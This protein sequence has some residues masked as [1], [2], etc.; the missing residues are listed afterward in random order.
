MNMVKTT[1]A[2]IAIVFGLSAAFA[3]EIRPGAA[4]RCD[5]TLKG[6]V[7]EG[8]SKA[9]AEQ[10]APMAV[11]RQ[12]TLCLD[13]GGGDYLEALEIIRII[14]ASDAAIAT[15]LERSARCLSA[16]ALVFLA[17]HEVDADDDV[18][19]ART[20]DAL[21]QLGFHGPYLPKDEEGYDPRLAPMAYQAGVQA[22]GELIALSTSSDQ[23]PESLLVEALD[24]DSGEFLLI[25]TVDKAGLWSIRVEG[26]R[27]PEKLHQSMLLLACINDE[28]WRWGS[29]GK[30]Y[31]PPNYTVKSVNVQRNMVRVNFDGFGDEAAF[32]CIADGVEIKPRHY[33]I[34]IQWNGGFNDPPLRSTAS[35]LRAARDPKRVAPVGKALWTMFD[36]G[37]LLKDIAAR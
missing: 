17:G 25:D 19:P 23:F 6:H 22:I 37:T 4:G 7:K 35:L 33:A 2:V 15:R 21:S 16:C 3:A 10:L 11:K 5:I 27:T 9:F 18:R 26:T 24:K 30:P 1:L 28:D 36:K 13:S 31:H 20:M 8:D 32:T 34:D 14:I 29:L 12:L